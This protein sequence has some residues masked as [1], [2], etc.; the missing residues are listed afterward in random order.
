MKQIKTVG[1]LV[2]RLA[3]TNRDNPVRI[4]MNGVLHPVESI[5]LEITESGG[6]DLPVV[7]I[8]PQDFLFKEPK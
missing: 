6:G 5:Q 4:F 8:V 1:G 7:W 3:Q 2:D